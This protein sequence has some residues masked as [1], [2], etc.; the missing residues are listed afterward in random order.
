MHKDVLLEATLV[1][2]D[3]TGCLEHYINLREISIILIK[4]SFLHLIF[5]SLI[6]LIP[7]L[8]T[9]LKFGFIVLR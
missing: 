7:T 8:S 6:K 4:F 5:H 1:N 9:F 2:F 3:W